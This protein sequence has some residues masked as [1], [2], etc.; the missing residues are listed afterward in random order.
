MN[1]RNNM[2]K[3]TGTGYKL[4]KCVWEITTA[5]NLNCSHCGSS[6]GYRREDELTLPEMENLCGQI[7]EMRSVEV[8]VTGGEPFLKKEWKELLKILHEYRLPYGIVCNGTLIDKKT[9]GYLYKCSPRMVAVSIDGTEELHNRIRRT[10]CFDKAL[11]GLRLLRD[12]GLP[13][14]VITTVSRLNIDCL[15]ELYEFLETQRTADVW[16]LQLCFPMGN[17]K[18]IKD[19][20]LDGKQIKRLIDFAYGKS[21]R[22]GMAINLADNIGYYTWNE[23]LLSQRFDKNGVPSV[24]RGCNAGVRSVGILSNG[25]V[26]ACMAIRDGSF[27]EGN[28]RTRSL[29][30]IWEDTDAFSWRR[31]L[32]RLQLK[33][34]CRECRYAE[35]CLGGCTN[36]RLLTEGSIYSENKYC[37]WHGR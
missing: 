6:C 11:R 20:M 1:L 36:M 8:G 35:M 7:A 2:E 31:G 4:E 9:A 33:G 16:R 37:A 14:G 27:I 17:G 21:S 28:I 18:D 34:Y 22:G 30:D 23:T 29:R 13:V 26:T 32:T 25:D 24:W 5:C 19:N 3:E 15:E 10:E 12:E